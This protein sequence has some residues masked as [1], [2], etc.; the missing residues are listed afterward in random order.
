M[1]AV[2]VLGA[3]GR[4]GQAVLAALRDAPDAR[5]A[6]AVER[7]GHPLCGTP[8]GDGQ[9]ICANAAPLAR[10]ADVLIDFTTPDAL[11]EH[12]RA[13]VDGRAALV[14]G[15][16]GLDAAHHAA[17]DRAARD[18][19]ILQAA[20]MSLG[21]NLLAALVRQAA[22]RLADWDVEVLELHHRHKRDAPS[23]TALLLGEAAA[24]GRGTRLDAVRT[25]LRDGIGEPRR[26]GSIGFAAMRGGSAAGDHLVLLATEGERLE[27]AHRA[28]GREIFAR[29]AV[30]A[31]LWL[32]GKPPGRYRMDDVLGV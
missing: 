31:A 21:V 26:E 30:R 23:G 8:V 22:A 9:M 32:A 14:V 11:D 12:L 20:N 10:A 5:L 7:A 16:T 29:G 6:G 13:A 24:Q 27:L 15:T 4:M 19:A 1:T 28:E 2:G 18:V 25:R 3:G 17:I